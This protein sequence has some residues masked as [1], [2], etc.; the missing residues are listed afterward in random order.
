M[1]RLM[2]DSKKQTLVPNLEVA[3][4]TWTRMKGLLGRQSLASDHGMLFPNCNSAHTFFMKFPIDFVFLNKKMVVTKILERV[5]PG[6]LVLPVWRASHMIELSAGFLEKH[7][8]RVGE[9][10]HV[11]TALS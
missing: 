7:P 6:R 8:I 11:D 2:R 1:M 9:K 5:P 10:L 4:T 3:N